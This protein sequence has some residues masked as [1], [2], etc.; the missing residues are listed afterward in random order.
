[1]LREAGLLTVESE[2]TDKLDNDSFVLASRR[3]SDSGID[4][5]SEVE[6][7]TLGRIEQERQRGLKVAASLMGTAQM[8]LENEFT[9]EQ[10]ALGRHTDGS[11][12]RGVVTTL[13]EL[14]CIPGCKAIL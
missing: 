14:A 7:Y 10:D 6:E 1:M 11:G 12:I 5:G 3:S 8:D 13:A 2:V 9:A 4:M